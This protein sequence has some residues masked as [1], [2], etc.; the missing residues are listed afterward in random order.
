VHSP[1]RPPSPPATLRAAIRLALRRLPW[2]TTPRQHIIAILRSHTAQRIRFTTPFTRVGD[3]TINYTTFETVAQDIDNMKIKITVQA[4]SKFRPGVVAEYDPDNIYMPYV[5][6]PGFTHGELTVPPIIGRDEEGSA[7]HECTHAYFDLQSVDLD[8]TDDEAVRYVVGALYRRMTGLPAWR[9][10]ATVPGIFQASLVVADRLLHQYQ[11]GG[12]GIPRVDD[13]AFQVLRLQIA[14]D[15]T[16][17]GSPAD[18]LHW[19]KP[20]ENRYTHDG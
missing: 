1:T 7:I 4:P 16:Y 8:A 20:G 15:T 18:L 6:T 10:G 9:W 11:L 19:A 14:A 5:T 13:Q 3:V 12:A 17:I 2:L